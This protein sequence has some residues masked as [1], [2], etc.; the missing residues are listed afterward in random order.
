MFDLQ[1]LAFAADITRVFAFKL[2]RDASNRV[3]PRERRHHRVPHRVAPQRTRGRIIEF[4]KINKLPRQPA[5]VLP[6]Q[7]EEHARRR[8]QP[9][10]QHRWSSTARRW[11]TPNVH[12]HKRCPLFLAGHAGGALKGNLHI[13][14]PDGTPMA[15][16]MLSALHTL[17]VDDDDASATAPA[18]LDLNAA[19]S[20]H[21][22]ALGVRRIRALRRSSA[23]RRV[24][25]WVLGRGV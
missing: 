9:A 25:A 6:R 17:G 5:A 20:T 18:T 24:A 3:Y 1:A 13:K 7:A 22:G 12:N 16:A 15:N 19:A 4:A 14:A 10:R 23:S 8:R 2:G 11:A 21:D